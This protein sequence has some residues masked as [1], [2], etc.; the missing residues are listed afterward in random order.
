MGREGRVLVRC[1]MAHSVRSMCDSESSR[2]DEVNGTTD[3]R[4]LSQLLS[5]VQMLSHYTSVSYAYRIFKSKMREK[6]M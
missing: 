6:N 3:V 4:A 5:H 2:R 1:C